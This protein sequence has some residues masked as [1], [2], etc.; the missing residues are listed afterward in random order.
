[1]QAAHQASVQRFLLISSS[2]VNGDA[3]FESERLDETSATR[4]LGLYGYTKLA[5]EQLAGLWHQQYGLDVLTAR[6]TAI[7]GPWERDTGVRGT[8]SPPFQLV[9]EAL[10]GVPSTISTEGRRDWTLSTDVAA[11]I[12]SLLFAPSPRHRLYNLASGELWHPQILCQALSA[13]LPDW[14]WQTSADPSSC[15]IQYNDDLNRPRISP[16]LSGRYSS[17]F[18]TRFTPAERAVQIYAQWVLNH[19]RFFFDT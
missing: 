4:P 16:L 15:S 1:L 14:T 19:V 2:A 11:G 5:A 3:P 6:L 18:Q 17:E 10:R 7:F 8:L 12:S 9:N 13:V